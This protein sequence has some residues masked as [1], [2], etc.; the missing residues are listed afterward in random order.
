MANR[1]ITDLPI[2]TVVA[3]A[4]IIH[5]R[6]STTDK[7]VSQAKIAEYV[8]TLS[9]YSPLVV[10]ITGATHVISTTI[11]KQLLICTIAGNCTMTFPGSFGDAKEIIIRNESG[12][13]ANVI[14][15]PNLEILYPGSEI[16]FIWNGASWVKRTFSTYTLTGTA[17]PTITPTFLGQT[18]IDS[19]NNNIY[20]ATGTAS[21]ADWTGLAKPAQG[22]IEV[23]A[24][25][26]IAD[27]IISGTKILVKCNTAAQYGVITITLPTIADNIGKWYD[28]EHEATNEG[29]VWVDAEGSEKVRYKGRQISGNPIY[30]KGDGFRYFN[31]G[32]DWKMSGMTIL[33][34]GYQNRNDYTGVE[35]GN[36]V[37]YDNKSAAVDWSGMTFSDGTTTVTCIYDSGGTGAAGTLYFY[38][39]TGGTGVFTDGAT[40]T[41][42]NSDTA[43]VDEGTGASKNVDYNFYHNFGINIIDIEYKYSISTDGTDN[44]SFIPLCGSATAA[45]R[46]ET[47]F[48]VD[49]NS[50]KRQTNGGGITYTQDNAIAIDITTQDWYINQQL[51]FKA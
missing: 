20:I 11:R 34:I 38:N 50:I 2:T 43:D 17:A 31:N 4:D 16:T 3:P 35:M 1:T 26:V 44:N 5:C 49:L 9:D 40:L 33:T 27:T 23:T 37:T 39:I 28:I 24:D 19:S 36:G 18:F 25:Y 22:I 46:G 10:A 42:A 14:G 12:S 13:S 32:I 47:I 30:S 15:L 8:Q 7:S 48:Q 29:L 41:A 6:Q 51:Q 45:S 21:S